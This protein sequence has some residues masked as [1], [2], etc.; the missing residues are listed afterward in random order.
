MK[1]FTLFIVLGQ[2]IVALCVTLVQRHVA[3]LRPVVDHSTV[4]SNHWPVCMSLPIC[5]FLHTPRSLSGSRLDRLLQGGWFRYAST[6]FRSQLQYMDGQIYTPINVRMRVQ[7]QAFS[8]KMQKI[9]D[10]NVQRFRYEYGPATFSQ[11]K[12][13]LYNGHKSRLSGFYPHSLKDLVVLD[14]YSVFPTH[15]V[16]VYDGQRLVAVSFFDVGQQ[17][18]AS[19]TGLFDAAYSAYSLGYFTMLL[20]VTFCRRTNRQFY[21][22]GYILDMPTLYDY[23]LRIGQMEMLNWETGRW[24]RYHLPYSNTAGQR[25]RSTTEMLQEKLLA[26]DIKFR[27]HF[28]TYYSWHY[29]SDFYASSSMV[30]QPVLLFLDS[31]K[32]FYVTF[33]VEK[34]AYLLCEAALFGYFDTDYNTNSGEESTE[35]FSLVEVWAEE[36]E[37]EKLIEKLPQMLQK[38]QLLR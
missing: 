37:V 5:E 12:Q 36:R 23:K 25:I 26:A 19:I 32:R 4:L 15:E 35:V 7:E 14:P 3:A 31:E 22:P 9:F 16:C 2:Q 13:E 17:S 6:L 24:R 34:N 30:R 20:E 28:Y 21:Y 33:D 11:A 18:V 27:T 10:K 1:K 8:K 38:A 29:R